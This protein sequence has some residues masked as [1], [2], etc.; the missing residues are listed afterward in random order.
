MRRI[1]PRETIEP[2]RKARGR[3]RYMGYSSILVFVIPT[4]APIL[5]KAPIVKLGTF[6][7]EYVS[8]NASVS[9]TRIDAYVRAAKNILIFIN[10]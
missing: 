9:K 5:T 1:Q 2:T 6:V 8:V 3:P 7:K 4:Y 10:N